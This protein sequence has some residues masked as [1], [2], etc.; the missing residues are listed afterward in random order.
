[1]TTSR[2]CTEDALLVV[3]LQ[4]LGLVGTLIRGDKR[5]MVKTVLVGFDLVKRVV[6]GIPVLAI[7]ATSASVHEGILRKSISLAFMGRKRVHCERCSCQWLVLPDGTETSI[8][9]ERRH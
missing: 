9:I 8:R 7:A 5:A 4:L 6:T 2:L 3:A 1:M